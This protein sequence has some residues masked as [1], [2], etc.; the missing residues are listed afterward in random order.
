MYLGFLRA[1]NVGG[2]FVKMAAVRECLVE[3]GFTEVETYIQSGNVRVTSRARST[4]AVEQALERALA[5]GCGFDVPALVRTPRQLRE[6]VA[7]SPS[8]PLGRD[9]R[10]YLMFLRDTPTPAHAKEIAA[11][12]VDGERMQITGR[13]LHLWLTKPTHGA[14]I[15]NTRIEKLIGVAGTTRDWKVVSALAERWGSP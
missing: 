4:G 14:R 10:H 13:E 2:R 6:A 5:A 9:A 3:A 11:W 1:V 15:S 8:S 7:A 12:D